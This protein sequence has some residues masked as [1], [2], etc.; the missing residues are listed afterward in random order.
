MN[1]YLWGGRIIKDTDECLG[2]KKLLV[3]PMGWTD[4]QG[5]RRVPW[6]QKIYDVLPTGWMN[7]QGHQRVPWSQKIYQ[8]PAVDTPFC[9]LHLTS[10]GG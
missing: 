5:H 8:S 4:C 9:N 7:F 3:L 10:H 1:S 6:S 2:P